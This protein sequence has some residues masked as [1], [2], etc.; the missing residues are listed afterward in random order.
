MK[1]LIKF[2][3]LPLDEKKTVWNS[4]FWLVLIRLCLWVVSFN[5]LNQWLLRLSERRS[6]RREPNSN[7]IDQVV[8]SVKACSR[9]V[10]RATCL[11]QA[12]AARTL[13]RFSGQQSSLKIGVDKTEENK[14]TAHAWIELNGEIIIGRVPGH[15]RF[16]ILNSSESIVL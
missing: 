16:A 1:T 13:L 3:C 12:L 10:P 9:L 6:R 4:M 8:R 15:K 2:I 14:L 5:R 7:E 11:T